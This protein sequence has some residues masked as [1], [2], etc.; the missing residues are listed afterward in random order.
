[1]NC[2]SR[3]LSYILFYRLGKTI[4]RSYGLLN[5]GEMIFIGNKEIEVG[6]IWL[7]VQTEVITTTLDWIFHECYTFPKWSLLCAHLYDF[8]CIFY[9]YITVVIKS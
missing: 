1:M 4:N 6:S 5:E 3:F 8:R 2:P 9:R 7:K